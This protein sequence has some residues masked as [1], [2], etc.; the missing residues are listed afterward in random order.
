MRV[1][2]TFKDT[3]WALDDELKIAILFNRV[4]IHICSLEKF[5]ELLKSLK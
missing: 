4:G 1:Q 3:I 2:I 5:G